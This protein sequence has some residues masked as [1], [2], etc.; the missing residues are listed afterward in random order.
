MKFSL[1]QLSKPELKL[2]NY[3]VPI[4]ADQPMGSPFVFHFALPKARALTPQLSVTYS[5][6]LNKGIWGLG[7]DCQG[8]TTIK[9]KT[10]LGTPIY[11]DQPQQ[12]ADC[13]IHSDY[14]ELVAIAPTADQPQQGM[15]NDLACQIIYYQPR[16]AQQTIQ[17]EHW[18]PQAVASFWILRQGDGITHLLGDLP[19]SDE[20]VSAVVADPDHPAHIFQW[21]IRHSQD[22]AGNQIRYIYECDANSTPTANANRYPSRILYANYQSADQQTRYAYEIAFQY[23]N[24][25]NNNDT[26][27]PVPPLQRTDVMYD[28]RAGFLITT[29]RLCHRIELRHY[30]D[31]ANPA[32]VLVHYWQMQY[33]LCLEQSVL[34]S[35]QSV[36]RRINSK[37]EEILQSQPAFQFEYSIWEAAAQPFQSLTFAADSM[38]LPGNNGQYHLLDLYRE[39]LPGLLCV[40]NDAVLFW[41]S[42]GNAAFA[43]PQWLSPLP[44]QHQMNDPRYQLTVLGSEGNLALVVTD[45]NSSGYYQLRTD[46]S[47]PNGD[48]VW[49]DFVAFANCPSLA[50]QISANW[51]DITGNGYAD[52]VDLHAGYA[53]FYPGCGQAGFAAAEPLSY[54]EDD[55]VL[56]SPFLASDA[57]ALRTFIEFFGDGRLHRVEVTQ[58]QLIVWPN[59][60]HGKF[61]AGMVWDI[62]AYAGEFNPRCIELADTRH[63]GGVDLIYIYPDRLEIFFQQGSAFRPRNAVAHP[64]ARAAARADYT[65]VFPNGIVFNQNT[66]LQVIDLFSEGVAGIFLTQHSSSGALHYYARL[67]S[68]PAL[69]VQ[70][71]ENGSG[72][73]THLRY[74]SSIHA[75]L[76]AREIAYQTATPLLYP[77]LPWAIPMIESIRSVDSVSELTSELRHQFHGGHYHFQERAFGGF[78]FIET[79]HTVIDH[80]QVPKPSTAFN[81]PCVAPLYMRQ[82]FSCGVYQ[83]QQPLAQQQVAYQTA[84]ANLPIQV[85]LVTAALNSP[86]QPQTAVLTLAQQRN[87]VFALRNQVLRQETYDARHLQMPISVQE[88]SYAVFQLPGFVA[89]RTPPFIIVPWE[90]VDYTVE[91]QTQDHRIQ[92]NIFCRW[93]PQSYSALAQLQFYYGRSAAPQNLAVPPDKSV[94]AAEIIGNDRQTILA[95]QQKNVILYTVQQHHPMLIEQQ[96]LAALAPF[97]FYDAQQRASLYDVTTFLPTPAVTTAA[98]LQQA[99]S[100]LSAV[101]LASHCLQ[102]EQWF[103]WNGLA[104]DQVLPLDQAPNAE[105]LVHHHERLLGYDEAVKSWYQPLCLRQEHYATLLKTAGYLQHADLAAN[106]SW[107]QPGHVYHYQKEPG[108]FRL[109]MAITQVET[110]QPGQDFAATLWCHEMLQYD[111]YQLYITTLKQQLWRP[112][113][114]P[115]NLQT[116]IAYDYQSGLPCYQVDANATITV[117][118]ASPLGQPMAMTRYGTLNDEVIGNPL[119]NAPKPGQALVDY[120]SDYSFDCAKTIAAL[121]T[122]EALLKQL[123]ETDSILAP[124]ISIHYYQFFKSPTQPTCRISAQRFCYNLPRSEKVTVEDYSPYQIKIAYFNACHHL[125]QMKEWQAQTAALSWLNHGLQRVTSQGLVIAQALPSDSNT[126]QFQEQLNPAAAFTYHYYDSQQ[127]QIASVDAKGYFQRQQFAAWAVFLF[128]KNDTLADRLANITLNTLENQLLPALA[129]LYRATPQIHA[130]NAQAKICASIEILKNTVN[131]PAKCLIT[132]MLRNA[133]GDVIAY[134]DP[135]LATP[136]QSYVWNLLRQVVKRDSPDRGS[137]VRLLNRHEKLQRSRHS[138]WLQAFVYDNWQRELLKQIADL[139]QATGFIATEY[140]SYG[141]SLTNP[142]KNNHYGRLLISASAEEYVEYASYSLT[143]DALTTRK[144]LFLPDLSKAPF[145]ELQAYKTATATGYESVSIVREF[146]IHGDVLTEQLLM[147]GMQGLRKNRYNARG[148]PNAYQYHSG[149]QANAPALTIPAISYQATGQPASLAYGNGMQTQCQYDPLTTLL[150]QLHTTT[151]AGATILSLNYQQ[152]PVGNLIQQTRAAQTLSFQAGTMALAATTLN[153]QYDTVYQLTQAQGSE[154]RHAPLNSNLRGLHLQRLVAGNNVNLTLNTYTAKFAHDL[155]ANLTQIQHQG[156]SSW[157]I[158]YTIVE[159]SNRLQQVT[160]ANQAPPASAQY[161]EKGSLITLAA[162]SFTWDA[163]GR[164]ALANTKVAADEVEEKTPEIQPQAQQT[165]YGYSH[166]LRDHFRETLGTSQQKQGYS[167]SFFGSRNNP[168]V[169]YETRQYKLTE[170]PIS[171]NT[172]EVIEEVSLSEGYS[173]KRI[174]Q[175]PRQAVGD[176]LPPPILE[177]YSYHLRSEHGVLAAHFH[178]VIDRDQRETAIV[179]TVGQSQ[180]QSYYYL[181]NQLG[182]LVMEVASNLT[183]IA[184]QEYS[185]YGH[186]AFCLSPDEKYLQRQNY[187]YSGKEQDPNGLYYYGDRYYDPQLARWLNPDPGGLIDS[188]NP[189][190]FVANNPWTFVDWNGD[191]RVRPPKERGGVTGG[192]AKKRQTTGLKKTKAPVLR[193]TLRN[194]KVVNSNVAGNR[195]ARL[196]PKF[197]MNTFLNYGGTDI[198]GHFLVARVLDGASKRY[199]RVGLHSGFGKGGKHQGASHTERK[200]AADIKFDHINDEVVMVGREPPCSSCQSALTVLATNATSLPTL[201][202]PNTVTPKIVRYYSLF[203]TPS[204]KGDKWDKK[205]H[206]WEFNPAQEKWGHTQVVQNS[207]EYNTVKGIADHGSNAKQYGHI[208]NT[209]EYHDQHGVIRT[210]P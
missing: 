131:D 49:D 39:G 180:A 165:R 121:P 70:Q 161:D 101:D 82:W 24:V 123:H 145:T 203:E 85:P 125:A 150:Q 112:N 10:R 147:T 152:D 59:L 168:K 37:R 52:L 120:L 197:G 175:L 86:T 55:D 159:N 204:T 33:D 66:R 208:M 174:Y 105:P 22:V 11:Q 164:L 209:N 42:A 13:F 128:D 144:R 64:A 187:H 129:G 171:A 48:L 83:G 36:G 173:R 170:R 148:L 38:T 137:E 191:A 73:T 133:L 198:G 149:S 25:V 79:W 72:E 182:S 118:L 9:R 41:R 34:R 176:P 4:S 26:W 200:L 181:L 154:L 20:V 130:L 177:R 113:A 115:I 98:T 91:Q 106:Q 40:V 84:Y 192:L 96:A 151:T 15:I 56:S 63:T 163:E 109:L 157:Q 167:A 104:Q 35:F 124:W 210:V 94:L 136:S 142:E 23:A 75:Y 53:V 74:Q 143:G 67:A 110:G 111:P 185:A 117:N 119:P 8:L 46:P 103:Y 160:F 47:K 81:A 202:E 58:D 194:G 184:Y 126:W 188:L 60:G 172:I 77:V 189:Y 102:Q 97:L 90:T 135:R 146:S 207:P 88:N 183:V 5:S 80:S 127:R 45:Q 162:D 62:P 114:T 44:Q 2:D 61:G 65:L 51:V 27:Q 87:A 107:W 108:Q 43:A 100:Q 153:A 158:N 19:Q 16:S 186:I 7:F 68:Q 138:R 28:Y 141:E 30:F 54:L 1:A 6:A 21:H 89:E 18:I 206:K 156:L 76:A 134:Y 193:Y 31:Q 122:V 140:F 3:A 29:T 50:Q 17:L 12:N 169:C 196:V 201:G 195:T 116:Q 155:G 199:F 99:L 69:L 178:W 190:G 95:E 78:A 93:D 132:R 57:V 32:E 205:F 14:G 139:T 166:S 71:I 179:P 92:R